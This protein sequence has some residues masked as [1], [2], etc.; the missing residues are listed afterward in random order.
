ML[1]SAGIGIT[2]VAAMVGDLARRRPD[3]PVRL[4]HVDREPDTHALVSDV[5]DRAQR[6]SDLRSLTWY[7]A[8]GAEGPA[9]RSGR[10]DLADIDLPQTPRVFLCGPLPFMQAIRSALTARGI[11]PERIEYEVFGPD[12]WARQPKSGTA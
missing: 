2:P 12:L 8:G 5:R 11:A 9:V 1:I 4:F 7:T 6:L 10:M 3:R